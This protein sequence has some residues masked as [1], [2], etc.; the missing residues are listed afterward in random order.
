MP[1]R[2]TPQGLLILS[3]DADAK[4]WLSEQRL[5]QVRDLYRVTDLL[6][7]I[8]ISHLLDLVE[9]VAELKH[10]L[11]ELCWCDAD[12]VHRRSRAAAAEIPVYPTHRAA[13]AG[14][15]AKP[16]EFLILEKWASITERSPGLSEAVDSRA[17]V[18]QEFRLHYQLLAGR[19]DVTE[20][21]LVADPPIGHDWG[22]SPLALD[23]AFGAAVSLPLR[24]EMKTQFGPWQVSKNPELEAETRFTLLE[25]LSS[26]Y[27]SLGAA[28][29]LMNADQPRVEREELFRSIFRDSAS[30]D[31]EPLG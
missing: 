14:V 12:A 26:I 24:L 4:R 29:P 31:E 23:D 30:D 20:Q 11:G 9:Q 19:H 28:P 17:P 27:Y 25:I 1:A 16:A 3:W 21:E 5:P 2:L 6:P 22:Q 13:I 8:T 18:A 10:F 7:G 15:G